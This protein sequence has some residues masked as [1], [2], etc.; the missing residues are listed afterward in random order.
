MSLTG[1]SRV[2][3]KDYKLFIYWQ[4]QN[5]CWHC[6]FLHTRCWNLHLFM[7]KLYLSYFFIIIFFILWQLCTLA[8]WS[9]L[10]TKTM[11]LELWNRY[12][13]TSNT[14]FGHHHQGQRCHDFLSKIFRF[15]VATN[16]TGYCPEIYLL[17]SSGLSKCGQWL[18][19]CMA[20]NST[21]IL[22]TSSYKMFCQRDMYMILLQ[23]H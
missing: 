23:Q 7:E 8:L 22:S 2:S 17:K 9:C 13:L 15:F 11:W 10:G 16:K 21:T 14:C 19:S 6:M 4:C 18:G 3:Q 20:S 5:K 12:V 1:N